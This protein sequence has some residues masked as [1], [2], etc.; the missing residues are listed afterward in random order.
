M[1]STFFRSG[2]ALL[3]LLSSLSALASMPMDPEF[4]GL[5]FESQG[6]EVKVDLKRDNIYSPFE[7][8]IFSTVCDRNHTRCHSN[9]FSMQMMDDFV[10]ALKYKKFY[11]YVYVPFDPCDVTPGCIPMGIEPSEGELKTGNDDIQ[12]RGGYRPEPQSSH[13]SYLQTFLHS[14]AQATGSQSIG[15]M[16]DFLKADSAD[17][18]GKFK[19]YR[20]S[21]YNKRGQKIPFSICKIVPGDCEEQI[22]VTIRDLNRGKIAVSVPVS[23]GSGGGDSE[24]YWQREKDIRDYLHHLEYECI[25]AYT[26]TGGGRVLQMVCVMK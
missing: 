9:A 12:R 13:P 17:E 23:D 21:S 25:P 1:K 8:I 4:R 18:N 5:Y 11:K 22:D 24:K 7:R 19:T 6:I 26:D 3:T 2:L 20:F 10:A 15:A 14:M 16:A